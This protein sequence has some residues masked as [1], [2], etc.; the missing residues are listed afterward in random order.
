MDEL[1]LFK[2]SISV[3]FGERVLTLYW[4][5]RAM[6]NPALPELNEAVLRGWR[7]SLK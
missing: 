6:W 1:L 5:L 4:K 7:K 3:G 2:Q